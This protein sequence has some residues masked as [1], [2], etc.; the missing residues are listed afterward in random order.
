MKKH[1]NNSAKTNWAFGMPDYKQDALKS[2]EK[3]ASNEAEKTIMVPHPELK[4]T[5]ILK[6]AV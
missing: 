3:C 6:K 4:K 2:A 1:K 5:W